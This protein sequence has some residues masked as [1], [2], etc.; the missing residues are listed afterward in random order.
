MIEK[1]IDVV[2]KDP[3]L[4][5]EQ[6]FHFV[7]TKFVLGTFECKIE[8]NA[9]YILMSMAIFDP[10]GNTNLPTGFFFSFYTSV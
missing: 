10:I 6:E 3:I 5:T 4:T 1:K 9:Y 8:M 7:N 2:V